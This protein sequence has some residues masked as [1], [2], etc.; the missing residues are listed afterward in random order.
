M[1]YTMADYMKEYRQNFIQDLSVEE[2]LAGLSPEEVLQRFSPDEGLQRC[3][4]DEIEA[5][6]AKLK[7]Q[8]PH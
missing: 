6:L 5:Y 8:R 3:S 2:R 1:S 7:S 4:P